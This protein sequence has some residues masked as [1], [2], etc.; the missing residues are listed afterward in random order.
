MYVDNN[1]D[2]NPYFAI[3]VSSNFHDIDSLSRTEFVKKKPIY[4]SINIQSL[5]SKFDQLCVELNEF[6]SKN[7]SIDIIALQ[8]IWD[9]SHP[10]LFVIPGYKPLICKQRRGMRGGGVGFFVKD[11]INAQIL[12]ELSPFENKIIEAVTIRVS[13]QDKKPI[14]L[15]SLYR[16][17]GI[18]PNVTSSQQMERF[19]DK[20]GN[21]L[22]QINDCNSESYLFMDSNI[23]LLK[24]N[25]SSSANFL[26]LI[27]EKSFLQAIGKAT[28]FQNNSKTLLDQIIFNKKCETIQ[29][30]TLISDVSDHFFTFIVPPNRYIAPQQAH[31]SI[32]TRDYSLNNLNNFKIQLSEKNWD[33]VL[34]S[35][36]VDAAYN[37]FWN[38]YTTCHD[39]SFPL[40]RK[41]F[42]KNFHKKKPFM[43][44]GLL[45][46]RKTKNQLHKLSISEPSAFNTQKYK[47]YKTLYF[48][49]LR[50][51][52]KLYFTNKLKE[53]AKNPKK[54]WQ[55]LNEILGKTKK[56]ESPSEININ[57][58]PETD[59]TKIADH[60]NTFFTSVGKKIANDVQNV[61]VQPEDYI[62]Y[63][64]EIPQL[65]LGNTTREH[66]LKIIS[67]FKAKPS[68]DI[69]GVSTKMI[70]FIGPEIAKPLAHIFNLSL[71]NGTFP[72][73][74]KQCRVIPIFKAGSHLECDNYRPISLLSSIS[75][76]LEKIVAEKLLFHL[77]SNDLLYT[78]QYGF[79]PNRSAEQNLLHIVNYVTAALNDGNF[80]VGVF[81]DL[82]KAFDV[83]SHSILLK[84]LNKMGINGTAHKWFENYLKGRSQKVDING[85]LSSEQELDISVIQGST[86]GPI[87]FLCYI[88]DF[89]SA[90]TLFSVLFADDTTCLSQGKK[91]N[92]LLEY[93]KNELQKI[94][95]WFRSNKM[96]VNTSKTKFIVFRTHG[97][98][99]N[100]EECVLTFNNN[101]PGQPVDPSLI[102][103]ID[104][105]YSDGQEKNFKLLGILFDEY[106]SF[107]AHVSSLCVKISKSLFCL[108]RI[109]NFIDKHSLK[110]LYYAMVHSHLSYCINVYGSA[111][112]TNLQRLRVKQKEAIRVINNAGYRDHT[113]PLF[114]ENGILAIDEMIK[115]SNLLFMHRFIN[116]NLPLSFHDLWSLNRIQNPAR[117]LRNAND[118]RIPA[119]NYAT[120]KRLPL[121]TF[122]RIW[123]EEDAARK[124]IP[125]LKLYKKE[126]RIA[127]LASIVI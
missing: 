15:T 52:K 119:H 90:T 82:K 70:K 18:L 115:L 121:F 45:I 27:F 24:L 78:H 120:L 16:S 42:N 57:D 88:N 71:T 12:D 125:S 13:Y 75:K 67:K 38:I 6:E 33:N 66:I 73:M 41:R 111:N 37:E 86:L 59:P 28:R 10:E 47:Q 25:E 110:M 99:I 117:L 19:I 93:V 102:Y 40:K 58:V 94:A 105:I 55:T 22:A 81:L 108:N 84:K 72:E 30:G 50:G 26:N 46:S 109:K 118:L 44:L 61:S 4:L 65:V 113:A 92:D 5:Q 97:K 103:N 56:C 23:D 87:L 14:L 1:I 36:D 62:N 91:L 116:R 89:Y 35:L 124:T 17:N 20:F 96:A 126:T 51:A 107:D 11:Y 123:N 114:K 68:K 29:S 100:P 101:E 54:I 127:L 95:V 106:L 122:P 9:V 21:L 104:R 43:T 77:N 60:F 112:T 8:E 64:R 34:N 53:N 74:L 32:V 2:D 7:V 3:Q 76:I 39:T 69:H 80:C 98:K 48:R 63:G 79:I 83:C 85:H 31:P 49:T